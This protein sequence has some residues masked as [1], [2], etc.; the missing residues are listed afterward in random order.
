MRGKFDCLFYVNHIPMPFLSSLLFPVT[1]QIG[2]KVE[3]VDGYERYGD[4]ASGPLLIGD[5]GVVVELQR[6]PNGE[7]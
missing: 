3:L 2:D 4:A 7:K 1:G 6:G 5:R